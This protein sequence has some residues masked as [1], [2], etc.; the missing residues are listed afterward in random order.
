MQSSR[1]PAGQS[2][3]L[4]CGDFQ[5]GAEQILYHNQDALGISMAF[6]VLEAGGRV[7]VAFVDDLRATVT[8]KGS[9]WHECSLSP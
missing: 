6:M 3:Q 9:L 5:L 7:A 8:T 2:L 4:F 1:S